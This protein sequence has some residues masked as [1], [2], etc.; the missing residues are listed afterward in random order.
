MKNKNSFAVLLM[1]V[2]CVTFMLVG[3]NNAPT[4]GGGSNANEDTHTYYTVAF[5][6]KGGSAVES[7]RIMAGNPVARS[8]LPVYEG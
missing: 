2:V 6:S 8:A 1:L 4:G 3:C 5:D 7:Q